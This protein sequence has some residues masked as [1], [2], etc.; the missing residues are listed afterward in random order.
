MLF[1]N[2]ILYR[3]LPALT[4]CPLFET[5]YV[6]KPETPYVKKE[7]LL[8]PRFPQITDANN[9]TPDGCPNVAMVTGALATQQ[10]GVLGLLCLSETNRSF[11]NNETQRA[12]ISKAIDT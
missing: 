7:S 12:A 2:T 4:R 10:V 1:K 9:M 8:H 3:I 11:R 6:Y 5:P